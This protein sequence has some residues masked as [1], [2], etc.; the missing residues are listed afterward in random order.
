VLVNDAFVSKFIPRGLDPTR[1]RLDD[2]VKEEEWT[3]IVG[4]TGNVR[5][6]HL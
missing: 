1:Q 2:N 4:V 6:E 5:Q 3:R